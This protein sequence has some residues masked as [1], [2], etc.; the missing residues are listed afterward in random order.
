MKKFILIGAAVLAVAIGVGVFSLLSNLNSLVAAAIEKNGSEVTETTVSVSGVDIKLRDGRGSISGLRVASPAG[1]KTPYAFV[2]GD[3][4]V[5]LDVASVR[6]DPIV[7][8]EVRIRA[9]EIRAEIKKN[10]TSNVEELR[11][12][13]QAYGG[14]KGKTGDGT[15]KR[16][17]IKSFIFE[18]GR[19]ELDAS[20]LGVEKRTLELPAIRLS[21]VGGPKGVPPDDIA[22]LILTTVAKKTASQIASS[23]VDQLIKNQLGGSI[24]DKAKGLLDKIGK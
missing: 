9:P 12:R 15:Q 19:I 6:E 20:D 2:L 24:S 14:G 5:D 3:I 18:K 1:F 10:G 16:I 23:E 21:D 17:R 13:V 8:D 11:K 22:K 4:T 7:L